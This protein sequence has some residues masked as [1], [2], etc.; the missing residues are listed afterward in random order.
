VP[1]G[2]VIF[3]PEDRSG[4][5]RNSMPALA[6]SAIRIVLAV[7]DD[8]ALRASLQFALEVEGFRVDTFA[9]GDELLAK[10]PLP[11][12]ACLLLDHVVP[13]IDGFEIAAALRRQGVD[14]PTVLITADA[15]E[16]LRRRAGAAGLTVVEKPLLG[17]A[18]AEAIR[19][20]LEDC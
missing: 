5:E 3:L 11:P 10:L 2:S 1:A 19:I 20:A 14:L 7:V 16:A 13:R 12:E 8:P 4:I 9:A 18:L 15:G 6:G 17:N